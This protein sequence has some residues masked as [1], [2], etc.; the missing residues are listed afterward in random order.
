[1]HRLPFTQTTNSLDHASN[2]SLNINHASTSTPRA[3]PA[4]SHHPKPR[5]SVEPSVWDGTAGLRAGGA[6]T[7]HL[8]TPP[9]HSSDQPKW[10]RT[11]SPVEQI[12]RKQPNRFST[13]PTLSA[14]RLKR[15]PPPP[16][17][18]PLITQN[19]QPNYQEFLL[20]AKFHTPLVR[21]SPLFSRPSSPNRSQQEDSDHSHPL[22]STSQQLL[23]NNF[24]SAPLRP[25]LSICSS[26]GSPPPSSPYHNQSLFQ[27]PE[28]LDDFSPT[29][30][31]FLREAVKDRIHLSDDEYFDSDLDEWAD[32]AD[33]HYHD[34]N[35]LH[36][37]AQGETGERNDEFWER[38]FEP[39][40]WIQERIKFKMGTG[41]N[42]KG[43]EGILPNAWGLGAMK[44][45]EEKEMLEKEAKMERKKKI[46]KKKAKS[47]EGGAK[48]SGKDVKGQDG[49]RKEGGG[50][51][52]TESSERRKLPFLS[53]LPKYYDIDEPFTDD[54][55]V[56]QELRNEPAVGIAALALPLIR[57]ERDRR[58]RRRR[59]GKKDEDWTS[60]EEA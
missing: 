56:E 5:L 16:P 12:A 52:Q 13:P 19:L 9:L 24:P 18:P 60:D 21:P 8:P 43:G 48:L 58:K 11:D 36:E 25:R 27:K 37:P 31:G 46:R 47:D 59:E 15:K 28:D 44:D 2:G 32:Q 20:C 51:D 41:S 29:R 33:P 40:E 34:I 26:A 50:L 7:S 45:A 17:P 42:R 1:M 55:E 23:S 4:N 10:P 22:A 54:S 3:P 30:W 6:R 57:K 39:W 53:R 14:A 35:S 49:Q 38:E